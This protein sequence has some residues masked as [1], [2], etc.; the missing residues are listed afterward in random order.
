MSSTKKSK[1]YLE[2]K[3]RSEYPLH[4]KGKLARTDY[5]INKREIETYVFQYKMAKYAGLL[6]TLVLG[7]DSTL[8]AVL[9]SAKPTS[10]FGK[11]RIRFERKITKRL[12]KKRVQREN[13]YQQL[14]LTQKGYI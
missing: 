8:V 1:G 12:I 9:F 2:F 7:K 3:G 13:K 5:L 6:D 4:L 14:H 11:L 10:L